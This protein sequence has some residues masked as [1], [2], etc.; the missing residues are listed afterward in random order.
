MSRR[1]ESCL[2]IVLYTVSTE[3]PNCTPKDL[4][5]R[6][7][8]ILRDPAF[9]RLYRFN[10]NSISQKIATDIMFTT[11][12]SIS[13]CALIF[14]R[15]ILTSLYHAGI[16]SPGIMLQ[17]VCAYLTGFFSEPKWPI[18]SCLGSIERLDQLLIGYQITYLTKLKKIK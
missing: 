2:L 14:D 5:S 3:R 6:S 15:M 9:W 7:Q 4:Q 16:S 18:S 10:Q 1:L 17:Y 11:R 8:P 13:S 12:F